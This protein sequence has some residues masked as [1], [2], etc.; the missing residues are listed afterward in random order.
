MRHEHTEALNLLKTAKGQMDA[1]IRMTEDERYCV[2]ISN[3]IMAVQ[4]LMKKANL[5][6][7]KKHI[8]SCVKTSLIDGTHEEKIEEVIDILNKYIK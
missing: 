5:S 1:I 6:I 2:D 8:N 7:L 3:Q 4:A